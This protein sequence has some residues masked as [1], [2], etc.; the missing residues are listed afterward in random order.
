MT[1]AGRYARMMH[2]G[3]TCF[4]A[5]MQ[6]SG[7]FTSGGGRGSRESREGTRGGRTRSG[8]GGGRPG[9]GTRGAGRRAGRLPRT[10]AP[11]EGGSFRLW[12]CLRGSPEP[13]ACRWKAGRKGSMHILFCFVVYQGL[14]FTMTANTLLGQ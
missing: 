10:A 14:L 12:G 6:Q 13:P 8:R 3:C 7:V 9:E 11:I 5:Q 2:L 1:V 4:L